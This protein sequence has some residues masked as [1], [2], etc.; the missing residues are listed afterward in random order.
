MSSPQPEAAVPTPAEALKG[1]PPVAPPSG[2]FIV[3]LFLV[4]GLIVAVAV[5]IL[6]G[7]KFLIGG[8]RSADQY[9]RD[10]D[11]PNEEVRWR[12]ANDLAQVLQRPESLSL[13]SDPSASD[14]NF[15]LSL[16]ERLREGVKKLEEA[17][18]T[19]GKQLKYQRDVWQKVAARR[20]YVIF[21]IA[22]LGNLTTPVGG[23]ILGDLAKAGKAGDQNVTEIRIAI[24]HR[25]A[26]LAL[27]KLGENLKRFAEVPPEEKRKVLG[28]LA[29][30][31]RGSSLRA[32]WARQ[33]L[34]YFRD[35][36][37]SGLENKLA[38]RALAGFKDKDKKP[39]G[40]EDALATCARH[41][42]PFERK[43]VAFALKYWDPQQAESILD[44]LM[45]DNGHGTIVP[46][47]KLET[48]P[49]E[50]DQ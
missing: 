19:A 35:N 15:G 43:L 46:V 40:V 4:P 50:S 49:Q 42:D 7:F 48:K 36:K 21:L 3:Q 27:A 38:R 39:L 8:S 20:N 17:E 47:D 37:P 22:C 24:Q 9:L 44:D 33:A 25:Q 11:D 23:P 29:S 26:I 16:A 5:L 12:A 34:V 31:A 10:L 30:E 32:Q 45:S 13:A 2:R 18:D 14:P 28:E 6:L 1:L 41:D